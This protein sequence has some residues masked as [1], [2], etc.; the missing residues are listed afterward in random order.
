MYFVFIIKTTILHY[1]LTMLASFL[2]KREK[3]ITF[4]KET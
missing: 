3:I 1:P 2:A 4:A